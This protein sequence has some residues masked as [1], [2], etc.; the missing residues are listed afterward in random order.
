MRM[1]PY[2]RTYRRRYN[3][4][5]GWEVTVRTT[6]PFHATTMTS[7]LTIGHTCDLCYCKARGITVGANLLSNGPCAHELPC[8]STT[9]IYVDLRGAVISVVHQRA[10]W[11]LWHG[12]CCQCMPSL[13]AACN[14]CGRPYKLRRVGATPV[15]KSAA[16]RAMRSVPATCLYTID[17]Q[18]CSSTRTILSAVHPSTKWLT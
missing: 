11:R 10:W 15:S 6:P 5:N 14:L 3:R 16:P 17:T 7:K 12:V 18:L 13:C 8:K 2:A 9:E 4:Y 1:Q